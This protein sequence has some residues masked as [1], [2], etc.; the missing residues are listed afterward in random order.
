MK[1]NHDFFIECYS[2]NP[3][4][5]DCFPPI[6]IRKAWEGF[7]IR[8]AKPLLRISI[9]LKGRVNSKTLVLNFSAGATC[10]IPFFD[11]LEAEF[12]K[13]VAL[14]MLYLVVFE[15]LKKVNF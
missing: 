4:P 5:F 12:E 6:Y 14:A 8:R 10:A 15:N 11:P 9:D 7:Y 13:I 3:A 1:T 2:K